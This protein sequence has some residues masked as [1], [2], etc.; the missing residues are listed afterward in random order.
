MNLFYK[1]KI[2]EFLPP[3]RGKYLFNVKMKKHTYM[4]VG[5][6]AET[7]FCP[8][9]TDDLRDFLR[10][11]PYNMPIFVMGG[12]SNLLVRDGGIVGVVI[13]LSS[14]FFK[15]IEIKN[16]KM[17][18]YAGVNN[19]S[20]KRVMIDSKLSGLEFLCTIPGTVGGAVRTNSGCFGKSVSDVLDSAMIMDSTGE[21]KEVYPEDLKLSYRSSLFPDD[22]IILSLTFNMQPCNKH[23]IKST[24][25]QYE[26]YRKEHQPYNEHTAGSF[27][28]NPEGLKAWQLIKKCG[29]DKLKHGGAEVSEKHCNFIV[30]TGNATAEDIE[31]LADEIVEKVY[32]QTSIR[33]EW[34]V[35]KVGI[36]K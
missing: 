35:K 26:Q 10:N 9:D 6:E 23:E 16:T 28:K 4:G 25:E 13:K 22:W 18:C 21:I 5:G 32:A 15:K 14:S 3:V 24:L 8:A 34:E 11:K 31:L 20:L 27:F 2:E 33:L 36:K 7:V 17:T 1:N 19:G 12:G 29:C 30:N